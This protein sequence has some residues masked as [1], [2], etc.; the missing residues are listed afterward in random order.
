MAIA[1]LVGCPA[2]RH[3]LELL[4]LTNRR[5]AQGLGYLRDEHRLVFSCLVSD[6]AQKKV[7]FHIRQTNLVFLEK[8]T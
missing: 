4:C 8:N 1:Q 3:V 5:C 2:G 6:N 7:I